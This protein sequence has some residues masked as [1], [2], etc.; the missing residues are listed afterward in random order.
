MARYSGRV[1]RYVTFDQAPNLSPSK[2]MG[3]L[4]LDNFAF[5][6]GLDSTR[7]CDLTDVNGAF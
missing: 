4:G 3:E 5:V 6:G 2:K 7:T 1:V